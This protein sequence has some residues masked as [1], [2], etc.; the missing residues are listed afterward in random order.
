MTTIISP[1]LLLRPIRLSDAERFAEL[2]NDESLTRQTSRLPFPYTREHADGFVARAI[3]EL[4]AGE[5]YRFAICEDAMLIAC[6]GVMPTSPGVFELGYW[7]G[8]QSRGRGVASEAASAVAQFTFDRLEGETIEAGHFVDNPASGRVLEKIGFHY[9][10][11]VVATHS[12]G[13]GVDV[14][15]K[16]MSLTR[17]TFTPVSS[18][19][20]GS[21]P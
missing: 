11:K 18:V 7:V 21:A 6:C 16:R 2:C 1:R 17:D 14:D 20:Y 5:E 4:E 19:E 13:R 3:R 10:G 9:T 15:A 12:L 8:A